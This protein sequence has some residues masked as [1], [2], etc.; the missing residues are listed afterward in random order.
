M[1]IKLIT[2]IYT[3]CISVFR[4]I[5]KCLK[6]HQW[7]LSSAGLW[8]TIHLTTFSRT[9]GVKEL[10]QYGLQKLQLC[11][12]LWCP[13]PTNWVCRNT[14]NAKGGN[15]SS[16][17]ITGCTDV[18]IHPQAKRLTQSLKTEINNTLT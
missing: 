3:A 18:H 1:L 17:L 6:Q 2:T 11:Q 5:A 10:L 16:T 9:E 7:Q 8:E 13:K 12:S 14:L 4:S 15:R